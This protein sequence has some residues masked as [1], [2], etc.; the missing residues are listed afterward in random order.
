[1][2]MRSS[3]S[4]S[5]MNT[6]AAVGDDSEEDLQSNWNVT[7]KCLHQHSSIFTSIVTSILTSIRFLVEQKKDL[8]WCLLRSISNLLDN[9]ECSFFVI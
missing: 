8:L 6:E 5:Q 9:F 3:I 7:K 1:M 2:R 4:H